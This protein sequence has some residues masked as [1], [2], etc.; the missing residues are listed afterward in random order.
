[1][2]DLKVTQD[3]CIFHQEWWLEAVAPGRWG[4]AEVNKGGEVFASMPYVISKKLGMTL[5]NMPSMTQTLGPWIK[6]HSGKYS[7]R[8]AQEKDLFNELM[9]QLPKFDLFRQRFSPEI[10]NWLPFF[11]NGYNQTTKYTYRLT[12][13][14]EESIL[15]DGLQGNIRREIKKASD[16]VT[17]ESSDDVEIMWK[18]WNM[19]FDRKN[20]TV[21]TNHAD[22]IRIDKACSAQDCRK[23]FVAKDGEQNIHATLYLV[24][25]NSTAYYL[26][27]GADP[28]YRTS[29]AASLLM[30]EAIKFT[31]EKGLTFDF[32]GSMIE[33]VERFFRG[34]GAVQTPYFEITKMNGLVK[35]V[36]SINSIFR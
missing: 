16:L 19:N 31:A 32:E 36:H 1:M 27:G 3:P 15:W 4:I 12:P 18:L 5:I 25:D 33:S 26:I 28:K 24:W 22:F 10:T 29:G 20:E 34:F 17:I 9:S 2:T 30:F 23:I 35:A 6:P 7:T 21:R 8:L 14:P 11:W 13:A